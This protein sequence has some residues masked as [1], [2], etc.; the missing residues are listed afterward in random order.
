MESSTSGGKKCGTFFSDIEE[1]IKSLR[2]SLSHVSAS[3]DPL[4]SSCEAKL[5]EINAWVTEQKK[6]S[7]GKSEKIPIETVGKA[8]QASINGMKKFKTGSGKLEVAEGILEIVASMSDLTG[9]PH[10][11]LKAVCVIVS[12]VLAYKRPEQASV[13]DRLAKVVHE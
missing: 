8:L 10:S 13:V 6:K 1:Q 12:A 3:G 9:E 4:K 5:T 7:Q 11:P 2:K